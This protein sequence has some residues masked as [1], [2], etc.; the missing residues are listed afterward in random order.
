MK[1]EEYIQNNITFKTSRSS[2]AGGQNVNKVET[3]VSGSLCVEVLKEVVGDR[4]DLLLERLKNKLT[5]NNILTVSSQKYRSQLKNKQDTRA[6][7]E[8]IV[9]N[10]LKP[11]IKRK[12]YKFN[13]QANLKRLEEKN[14]Q[15]QKKVNRKLPF[16]V[17]V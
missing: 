1:I 7:I 12:K 3:K 8:K 15:K 5:S 9:I 16:F 11:K 17:F 13:K 6:K 10:A 14:K 2:G 4:Y